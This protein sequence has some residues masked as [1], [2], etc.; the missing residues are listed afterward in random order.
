MKILLIWA[1][2]YSRLEPLIRK[3][4]EN[5]H[6]IPY[7]VGSS[8]NGKA[9]D[10][11]GTVFHDHY[12]AWVGSPAAGAALAESPPPGKG[13]IERMHKTESLVLTMMNKKFDPLCVDERRHIYYAMLGYWYGV[14]NKYKPEAIVFPDTPH[15]VYNYII[16]DLAKLLGIKTVMFEDSWVSDRVITYLDLWKGSERLRQ[17]LKNNSGKNFSLSDLSEDIR[18]YYLKQTNPDIDSTPEY[19]KFYQSESRALK[20]LRRRIV[21]ARQS[22]KDGALLPRVISFIAR[23]FKMDLK[24]EYARCAVRPDFS[25]PYVYVPLCFQPERTSSP[26]A[27]TFVDQI[28]MAE[29]LS[30]SLPEGWL[31]YVKEHP[32][33]WLLRAGVRYSGSRY[34]GYYRRIAGLRNAFLVPVETNS[35]ELMGHARA[36]AAVSGTAGWEGILRSRPMLNFG[37]PWYR[38]CPE[39][40]RVYDAESCGAALQKIRDGYKVDQQRVIGFLKSFDEATFHGYLEKFIDKASKV[41]EE[42]NMINLSKVI[43]EELAG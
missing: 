36:V 27:G 28:L 3:L 26:Q 22:V 19:T 39:A 15:T 31:M 43:M 1:T 32:T 23:K 25:K 10:L 29:I 41:G 18:E 6:E 34:A 9:P 8:E 7:W 17:R 2:T 20:R 16:H 42:E 40:F 38:D 30:Y 33:Q 21:I 12:A 13:L 4:E 24:K 35:F 5:G 37:Y 14:I 11:K